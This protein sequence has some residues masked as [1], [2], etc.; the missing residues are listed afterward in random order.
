MH[1]YV[2]S[3]FMDQQ[4]SMVQTFLQMALLSLV[5]FSTIGHYSCYFCDHTFWGSVLENIASYACELMTR[6]NNPIRRSGSCAAARGTQ[7]KRRPSEL[8]RQPLL[9]GLALNPGG[10]LHCLAR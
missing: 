1:K 5:H 3:H 4:I 7:L 10:Q 2:E 8:L 9:V 6:L